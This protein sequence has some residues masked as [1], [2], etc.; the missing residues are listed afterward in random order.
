MKISDEFGKCRYCGIK[1]VDW[2]RVYKCEERNI[3]YVF[4]SLKHEHFRHYMWHVEIDQHAINY[5]RRKGKVGIRTTAEEKIRKY[6]ATPNPPYDGRQTSREGAGNPICYAQHATATCCRKCAEYWHGIPQDRAFTEQEI[7]YFTE[8][9][10]RYIN[11]RLPF[12]T[13]LG[14][15]VPPI[16]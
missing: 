15:K 14:E 1:L 12:L 6:I 3:N 9:I 13:E 2:D 5:A 7:T 11:E 16:R 8:L 10:V 4:E